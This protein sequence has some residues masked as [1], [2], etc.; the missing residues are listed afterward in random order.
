MDRLEFRYVPGEED[1]RQAVCILCGGFFLVRSEAA[2]LYEGED[3][4]G[5]LCPE[6][7]ES[8]PVEAAMRARSYSD[9]LRRMAE[10][11]DALAS[12]VEAMGTWSGGAREENDDRERVPRHRRGDP[13]GYDPI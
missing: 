11:S 1:E 13:R 8:G 2:M 5:E 12:R 3:Y 6:C 10:A 9:E 4:L 7:V